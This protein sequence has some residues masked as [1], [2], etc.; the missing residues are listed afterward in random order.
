LCI[1]TYDEALDEYKKTLG[2]KKE[3]GVLSEKTFF[4]R[5]KKKQEKM[6]LKGILARIV[7]MINILLLCLSLCVSI[8][9]Y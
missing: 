8:F 7:P 1:F 3:D 2:F 4:Q 5:E 6:I 9:C